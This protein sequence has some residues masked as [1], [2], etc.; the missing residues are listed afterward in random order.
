V[1]SVDW[2]VM[3]VHR[4]SSKSACNLGMDRNRDSDCEAKDWEGVEKV[5][6]TLVREN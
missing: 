1:G 5:E 4:E 6:R 3:R 2:H